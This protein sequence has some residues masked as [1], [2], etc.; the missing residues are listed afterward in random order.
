MG[1]HS[2]DSRR[3]LCCCPR[4]NDEKSR[5]ERPSSVIAAAQVRKHLL[6][7]ILQGNMTPEEKKVYYAWRNAL[8]NP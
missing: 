6:T 1:R 5:D 7:K 4:L 3:N 8:T 2:R